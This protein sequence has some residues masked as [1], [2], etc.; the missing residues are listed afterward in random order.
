MFSNKKILKE[1]SGYGIRGFE[2]NSK[3]RVWYK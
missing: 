1:Q 2:E 3:R